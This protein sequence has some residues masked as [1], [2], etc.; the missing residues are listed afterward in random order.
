MLVGYTFI[1]PWVI[2][3][4]SLFVIPIVESFLYS[5]QSVSVLPVAVWSVRGRG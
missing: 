3:L 4:V 2:G 1:L 5:F